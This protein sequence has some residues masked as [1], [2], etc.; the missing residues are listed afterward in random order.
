MANL[1]SE[2]QL[3]H[4]RWHAAVV[5]DEGDDAGVEGALRRLVHAAHRLRVRLVFLAD[6]ARGARRRSHPG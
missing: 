3:R 4:L 6:A 2:S 1:V 5:I